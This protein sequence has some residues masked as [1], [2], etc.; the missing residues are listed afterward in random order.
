LLAIFIG[1]ALATWA[2]GARLA[3][4]TDELDDYFANPE[5]DHAVRGMRGP[6]LLRR[7]GIGTQSTVRRNRARV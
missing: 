6:G 4:N 7:V 5:T 1:A 3:K 2:L